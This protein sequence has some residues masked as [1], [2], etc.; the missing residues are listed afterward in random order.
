MDITILLCYFSNSFQGFKF[1]ALSGIFN[2][3][4]FEWGVETLKIYRE[5][6]EYIKSV[7]P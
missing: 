3:R 6:I 2:K 1:K 5:Y 4:R 7:Y